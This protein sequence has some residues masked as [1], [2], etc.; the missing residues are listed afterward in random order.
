MSDPQV[1]EDVSGEEHLTVGTMWSKMAANTLQPLWASGS[2][3]I[4]ATD[5]AQWKTSYYPPAFPVLT[6]GSTGSKQTFG[7]S[8]LFVLWVRHESYSGPMMAEMCGV[9]HSLPHWSF[10]WQ[11][12]SCYCS[13][14]AVPFLCCVYVSFS[15]RQAGQVLWN[16]APFSVASDLETFSAIISQLY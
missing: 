5:L 6:H 1:V 7:A 15:S 3:C 12:P 10:V 11:P 14:A 13:V 16:T 4:T 9:L 8:L 2:R